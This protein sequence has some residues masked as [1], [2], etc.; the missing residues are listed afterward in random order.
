MSDTPP[1]LRVVDENASAEEEVLRLGK[2]APEPV[3]RLKA[4]GPPE[5]ERIESAPRESFDGKSSEPDVNML[6][7][8]PVLAE[9]VESPWGGKDGR[10]AGVPYGWFVLVGLMLV[11]LIV[12]SIRVAG[13]GER[14][15]EETKREVMRIVEDDAA[16]EAVAT[17][18]V[19]R[20]EEVLR[21]YLAAETV[22]DTLPWIRDQE[23]VRP[24]LED[25]MARHPKRSLKFTRMGMFHPSMLEKFWLVRVDVENGPS[26][27]IQLEQTG[28]T[29]VKVDWESHV[30]YQ[31]MLW[32]EF[33]TRRPDE[34][35]LDFRVWITPDNHFSH[36]F[37]DSGRWVCFR[38]AAKDSEEWL[39]GYA[40]AGSEAARW[41]TLATQAS[42]DALTPFLLR[43]RVP[44]RAASPR[45]VVI[46]AVVT[47]SWTIAGDS[48]DGP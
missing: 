26:Q 37:S 21:S 27:H 33:V 28:D 45:G 13:R 3:A 2:K 23:R 39:Y 11:G 12:W 47:Q 1:K 9:E 34:R 38:L 35:A 20:V 46:E 24:L 25:W 4:G 17:Q 48:K 32:D 7:D 30:C 8:P 15:V 36:E 19:D 40:P 31:P 44:A 43:L 41:M 18:L 6:L 14:N 10:V 16:A 22:E 42:R 29:E 5:V